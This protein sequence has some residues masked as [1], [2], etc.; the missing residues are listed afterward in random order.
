MMTSPLVADGRHLLV[1]VDGSVRS[2]GRAGVGIVLATPD[3][4]PLR[5]LGEPLD[6]PQS[7][8]TAEYQALIRG[9]E[10]ALRLG[11]SSVEVYL[12]SELVRQQV[13]GNWE[14]NYEHLRALRDRARELLSQFASWQ[15]LRVES[16]FN[17]IAHTL[18][19]TASDQNRKRFWQHPRFRGEHKHQ[20]TKEVDLMKLVVTAQAQALPDDVYTVELVD[21][22]EQNGAYGEQFVWKLRV[23]EGEFAGT[24]LRAWSNA[25]T[26][27]NSKAVKW[28]S[29]FNGKPYAQGDSIDLDALK[30][31]RARA[32]VQTKQTTDGREFA[33]V[34][35]ILPM[36]RQ[37]RVQQQE[38][39][40]CD[41]F[42]E[43][44]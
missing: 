30:G 40:A 38:E 13:L 28:A 2:G 6:T 26:A 24:E 44:D 33:R 23:S 14:C 21:V 10:E 36:R 34:T 19:N 39:D 29:A 31:T 9:L 22:Q 1:Y 20:H 4:Y 35:D 5:R 43:E 25:S 32:V 11:A 27:V 16:R 7:S 37:T 8:N 42:L 41:P 12:D 18:A 3:G 15:L 17:P